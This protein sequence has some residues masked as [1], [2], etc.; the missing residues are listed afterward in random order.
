MDFSARLKREIEYDENDTF[1]VEFIFR[2]ER[3][4][5]RSFQAGQIPLIRCSNQFRK[6]FIS[7]RDITSSPS[8]P[9]QTEWN[10]SGRKSLGDLKNLQV[11]LLRHPGV[12]E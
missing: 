3:N 11:K 9:A 7:G 12:V 8:L 5:D 6:D 1:A 10:V 2:D 4:D